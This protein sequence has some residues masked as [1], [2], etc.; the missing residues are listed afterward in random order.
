MRRSILSSLPSNSRT[1]TPI[2]FGFHGDIDD[3]TSCYSSPFTKLFSP[4]ISLLKTNIFSIVQY[5][6]L[7]TILIF[8]CGNIRRGHYVYFRYNLYLF[9]SSF[10]A[11]IMIL[12]QQYAEQVWFVLIFVIA[13][14]SAFVLLLTKESLSLVNC[15]VIVL[16]YF[17]SSYSSELGI[18]LKRIIKGQRTSQY[19]H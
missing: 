2:T 12:Y 6:S 4:K 16:C 1:P 15:F 3:H 13:I 5:L 11:C 18:E 8:D 19:D 14:V 9:L 7:R 17:W 10:S